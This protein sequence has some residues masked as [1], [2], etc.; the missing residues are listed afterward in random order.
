MSATP[1]RH[2]P[3]FSELVLPERVEPRTGHPF[4]LTGGTLMFAIA[5]LW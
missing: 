2:R 3:L 4:Y 5:F 1:G